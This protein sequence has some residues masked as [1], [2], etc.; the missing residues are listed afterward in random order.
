MKTLPEIRALL[1]GLGRGAE[2]RVNGTAE[3]LPNVPVSD[4]F[5]SRA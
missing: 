2:M 3:K 1:D 5:G 4:S